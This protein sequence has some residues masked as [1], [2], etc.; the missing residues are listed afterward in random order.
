MTKAIT[1]EVWEDNDFDRLG[2]YVVRVGKELSETFYS[3]SR[4]A[5]DPNGVCILYT[6]FNYSDTVEL[7]RVQEIP[8]GI[9][10][11]AM[12]LAVRETIETL[13][14]KN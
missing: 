12:N 10:Q 14:L 3:M 1:I 2:L 4:R 13:T 11:Q 6:N 9:A 8:I 5:N 7:K